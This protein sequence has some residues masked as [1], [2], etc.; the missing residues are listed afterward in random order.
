MHCPISWSAC[1]RSLTLL[2]L[3]LATGMAVQAQVPGVISYQGHLTDADGVPLED[4]THALTVRLYTEADAGTPL[5]E[6]V[7]TTATRD[8]VFSILLGSQAPLDRLAFDRPYWLGV[9]VDG[10]DEFAP[11]V[12]LA[13]VPYSLRAGAVAEGAAVRSLNGL[14]DAVRL[15]AGENVALTAEGQT[16]TISADADLE[17]YLRRDGS[18]P[19]DGVLDMGGHAILNVATATVSGEAMPFGQGAGGDLAGSYPGPQVT[20]LQGRPLAAVAPT[21]GQVLTWGGSQWEPRDVP[22]GASEGLEL[23]FAAAVEASGAPAFEV[24]NTGT[25]SAA[26]F[27]VDNISNFNSAVLASTNGIG[28]AIFARTF[29]SGRAGLFRIDNNGNTNPA[30]EVVSSSSAAGS[31]ALL[32]N[33]SGIAAGADVAVFQ[34][35]ST[36][37]ARIDKI[38]TGFFDGGVQSSGADV[39]EAFDVEGRTV[40]YEAG[41]VLVI[42]TRSD[43]RV[44]RSSQPYSPLV[45]GVYATRPGV[46]LTERGI[47]EGAH[48]QI[49]MGV[50]GVV[51]TK[52]TVENGPIRR[53]DLLVTASRGGH[54][55][56]GTDRSRML[57]AVLGK[58]L[59]DFDGPGTGVIQ[60]LVGLR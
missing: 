25:R 30:V 38:G 8:G 10:S 6:E 29:G 60:V 21:A 19:M 51:P 23:P 4:G 41:D 54:A 43:R 26:N 11:R 13:T 1:I 49:P 58:A 44:T 24:R 46:L 42:S 17:A 50:V 57:G 55:M 2:I 22:E 37:V 40:D 27:V 14:A 12:P 34:S 5:W 39:A 53:G 18:R 35:G 45:A 33:H 9:A 20:A 32:V 36:N 16:L 48:Q 56:R 28:A 31:M 15:E 3:L 59:Q 52:V 7:Q 47:S